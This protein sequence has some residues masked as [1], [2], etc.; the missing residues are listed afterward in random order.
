L[1]GS[2]CPGSRALEVTSTGETQGT[3]EVS[4][5]EAVINDYI[6]RE[7]V[8]DAAL[9]PSA[10]ATPLLETGVFDSLTLLRLVFLVQE[11]ARS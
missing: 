10:N 7:L 6:G 1:G 5:L 11:R 4:H 9:L 2:Q 8:R 3:L